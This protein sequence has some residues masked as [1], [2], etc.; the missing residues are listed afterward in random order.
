MFTCCALH[1]EGKTDHTWRQYCAIIQIA[2]RRTPVRVAKCMR[3]IRRVVAAL[4]PPSI[5][6]KNTV[7]TAVRK[8]SSD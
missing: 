8:K 2:A 7:P 5:G 6:L 3:R 1:V 4:G